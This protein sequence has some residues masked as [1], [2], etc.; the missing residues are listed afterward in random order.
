MPGCYC[1]QGFRRI[2]RGKYV[3]EWSE[4]HCTEFA[5]PWAPRTSN[6]YYLRV[7]LVSLLFDRSPAM[8]VKACMTI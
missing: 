2:A 1:Q 6:H 8:K 7:H 4:L 5:D 3:E